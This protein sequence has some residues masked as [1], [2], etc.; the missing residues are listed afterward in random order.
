MMPNSYFRTPM[1]SN[2]QQLD[3]NKMNLDQETKPEE[4]SPWAVYVKWSA[5]KAKLEQDAWKMLK[6]VTSM[7]KLIVSTLPPP[8]C[9]DEESFRVT[10]KESL[11]EL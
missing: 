7:L 5:K 3:L 2:P 6:N 4:E 8:V 11:E 9:P 1:E 10:M